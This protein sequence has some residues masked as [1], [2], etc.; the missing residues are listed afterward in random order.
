MQNLNNNTQTKKTFWPKIKKPF[1]FTLAFLPIIIIASIL[2]CLYTFDLYPQEMLEEAIAAVGSKTIVILV[3]VIQ[4]VGII[5]LATFFGYIIAEKLGLLRSIKKDGKIKI[6][7][8]KA[9]LV[10]FIVSVISG[11]LFSLDYW[12][13]GKVIPQIQQANDVGLSFVSFIASIIYGGICEELMLRLFVL[14]LFAFIIWKLF[15]RKSAKLQAENNS[16]VQVP[17]AVFLLAN[18]VASLLFAAGHLPA[19]QIAF[20]SITPLILFRC[21]LYNGGMGYV[22]GWLYIK[23]GLQYSMLSHALCHIVSKAIWLLFI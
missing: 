18:I 10:T 9:L 4:N 13:F 16:Q 15:F 20:G 23:Y 1:L 14:S 11:I 19:T 2:T 22:F 5:A 12:T 8:K 17:P 21:F 6:F 7:E 3:T